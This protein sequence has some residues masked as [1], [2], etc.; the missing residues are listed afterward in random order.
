[1]KISNSGLRV[2]L[3]MQRAGVGRMQLHGW[4]MRVAVVVAPALGQRVG[5]CACELRIKALGRLMCGARSRAMRVRCCYLMSQEIRARSPEQIS[6]MEA[7]A[8]LV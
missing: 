8:G 5:D 4:S 2:R 1:M 7:A 6:V 3:N